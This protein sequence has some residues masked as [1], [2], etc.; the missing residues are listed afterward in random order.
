M[1]LIL[2][3]K[4]EDSKL[5]ARASLCLK[6]SGMFNWIQLKIKNGSEVTFARGAIN[7]F[8][9]K[10]RS[11]NVWFTLWLMG[12]RTVRQDKPVFLTSTTE[13]CTWEHCHQCPW[14]DSSIFKMTMEMANKHSDE[15]GFFFQRES[16]S[17]SLYR[18]L[19]HF[20]S[21]LSLCYVILSFVT[22]EFHKFN[23]Y[24]GLFGTFFWIT[25]TPDTRIQS[26]EIWGG[27]W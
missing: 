26:N 20:K 22:S 10:S 15:P 12:P 17:L 6:N 14:S 18:F 27:T 16:L 1:L 23:L 7:H 13:P 4:K 3:N 2:S 24:L 19:Y 21:I 25:Y 9:E 8:K 5:G 11:R